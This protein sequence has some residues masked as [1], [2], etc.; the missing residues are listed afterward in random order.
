LLGRRAELAVADYL[1]ARGLEILRANVRVGRLELDLVARD[2]PVVVV[3]EVRTRG[4]SSY[5]RAL[6]SVDPRKQAR[7][8]AAAE[9]LWREELSKDASLERLRFDIAS[10]T[11]EPG[12]GVRVEHV[13]AA[14]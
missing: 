10:V 8:R 14:F 6:D 11:F 2:G 4:A 13:R 9:R 1:A 12:G 5:Q 3:V 7:V